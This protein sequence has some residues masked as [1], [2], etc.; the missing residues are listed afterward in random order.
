MNSP[1]PGPI[2]LSTIPLLPHIWSAL[3]HGSITDPGPSKNPAHSI[4]ITQR[5]KRTLKCLIGMRHPSS[6][7]HLYVRSYKSNSS[8]V[9]TISNANVPVD[10]RVV[11]RIVCKAMGGVTNEAEAWL[12]KMTS[13]LPNSRHPGYPITPLHKPLVVENEFQRVWMVFQHRMHSYHGWSAGETD[14]FVGCLWSK[15]DRT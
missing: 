9:R 14:Q 7:M 10:P 3:P 1:I 6:L 4:R 13:A 11:V 15:Y 5:S 2:R 8:C 12:D